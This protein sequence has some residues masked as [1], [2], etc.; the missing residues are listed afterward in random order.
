V[1]AVMSQQRRAGPVQPFAARTEMADQI[2]PS[3]MLCP[4]KSPISSQLR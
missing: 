4:N 2:V 1:R 3:A